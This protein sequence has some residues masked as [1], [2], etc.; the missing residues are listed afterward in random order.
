MI[1][2]MVEVVMISARDGHLRYRTKVAPLDGSRHPDVVARSLA[3]DETEMLHST[4]WRHERGRLVLTYAALPDPWPKGSRRLTDK[5][6][7]ASA[8]ARRPSPG[9]VTATSVATHACR[10][11]AFLYRRDPVVR[12][13]GARHRELW[14][15]LTRLEPAVANLICEPA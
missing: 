3:G 8:D 4:A 9:R 10:H 5:Q 11:L 2:A 7:V 14:D 13:A 15:L 6:L 1:D 12:E